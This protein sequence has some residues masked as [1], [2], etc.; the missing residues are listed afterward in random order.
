[1]SLLSE[2]EKKKGL[3]ILI[4]G[5]GAPGI[6]G[7]IFCL[8]NNPDKISIRVIGIDTDAKAVGQFFVDKFYVVSS[9]SSSSYLEEIK[10][11]VND[12]HIDLIIP[13]TTNETFF[14]ASHKEVFEAIGVKVM[15]VGHQ[16]ALIANDKYLTFQTV[17]RTSLP[18][19]R[20]YLVKNIE[21][22]QAAVKQLGFPA[23][24]VVVKIPVSNG[25]RGFR[26]LSEETLSL[27]RFLHEK[28]AN[29]QI[30]FNDFVKMLE[31]TAAKMP[32]MLVMEYLPGSEYSVDIFRNRGE[33]S[34]VIPRLREKIRSGISFINCME[35]HKEIIRFSNLAAEAMGLFG[36]FGFQFKLDEA[37]VPKMLE[38]NPR[39]QGTMAASFFAG[40]NVIWY[41]V[42]DTLGLP[43]KISPHIKWGAKFYRYWGGVGMEEE[44]VSAHETI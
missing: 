7:T 16:A 40:A 29:D 35:H 18:V 11:I 12:N 26:I 17:A 13:Q 27:E 38:C 1:M 39:V 42:A 15:V 41:G 20:Y 44:K 2:C 24:K 23:K 31:V 6:K 10:K 19:A 14:Y 43:Y 8:L 9:C 28:P 34:V 32:P 5:A 37:G 22:L 30:S 4:T 25:M 33:T 3:N 36:V 21:E